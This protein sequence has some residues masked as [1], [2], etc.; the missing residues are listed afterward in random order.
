MDGWEQCPLGLHGEGKNV[1]EQD[2]YFSKERNRGM[3]KREDK[4]KTPSMKST[5]SIEQ[6]VFQYINRRENSQRTNLIRHLKVSS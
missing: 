6:T 1:K 4:S 2:I 3:I 5:L